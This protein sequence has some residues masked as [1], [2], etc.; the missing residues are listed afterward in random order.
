MNIRFQ[1]DADFNHI[2]RRALLRREPAVDFQTAP[3]AE[4]EGLADPE[5]LA[6][7]AQEDRVLVSHDVKTMPQHFADF[8]AHSPSP[9]VIIV[10]QHVPVSRVVGD[11]H[12]IWRATDAEAWHNQI[13]FL[14]L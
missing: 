3:V 12:L 6:I 4:L 9:G 13:R 10:P 11:L 8:V 2:I 1:A 14:P 5:V 7:A